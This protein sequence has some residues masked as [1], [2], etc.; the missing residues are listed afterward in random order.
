[1]QKINFNSLSFAFDP[2]ISKSLKVFLDRPSA[3]IL[4][5]F[6]FTFKWVNMDFICFLVSTILTFNW[7][8]DKCFNIFKLSKGTSTV[9]RS[10]HKLSGKCNFIL[11]LRA[12]SLSSFQSLTFSSSSDN[13]QLFIWS[14]LSSFLNLIK[15]KS[16]RGNP[17][18]FRE[19][20]FLQRGEAKRDCKPASVTNGQ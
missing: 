11:T 8:R 15:V 3:N 1:M 17:L 18:I 12:S 4:A 19:F 2:L 5:G 16:T 6:Y 14:Y 13:V 10:T 9:R 20:I 7:V